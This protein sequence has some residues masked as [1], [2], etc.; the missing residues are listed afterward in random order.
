MKDPM[1]RGLKDFESSPLYVLTN[2]VT[3]KDPMNRGLKVVQVHL[4]QIVPAAVTMK[5][6]MNRGL[7]DKLPRSALPPVSV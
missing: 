2:N 3:M 7:K 4:L 6:P 1:N 5:D